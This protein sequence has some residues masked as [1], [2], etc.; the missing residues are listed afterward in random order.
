MQFIDQARIA[1]K[2]GRGGDGICAFRREKYVPAGGPSGGDGGRGGDVVL[3]ADSNLQTLLD[4]KYKRLFRRRWSPRRAQPLHRSQRQHAADPRSRGTEVRDL[5]TDLL[6]GDLIDN[7]EQLVIA[8]GGKGAW[9]M[10][11]TSATA[12][13]PEK[14][15]EGK[16]GEERAAAGAQAAGRS[17]V[18]GAAQCR[19]APGSACS[20]PPG[21]RSP[22]TFTT[23][24]PNLG[25]VAA[26]A[27]MARSLLIFL[28]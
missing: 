27:A 28:G 7:G 9:A 24:V 11:T 14:F 6:L 3:Q 13:E 2:A 16:D 15:T 23:L 5:G 18:G 17:G 19:Q 26:P 22:I 1:V 25:V 8:T 12:T 20:R 4:F 10:P 21:P